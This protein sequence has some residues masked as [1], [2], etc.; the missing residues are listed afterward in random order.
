ML[1]IS[2][3]LATVRLSV[4]M[5]LLHTFAVVKVKYVLF[6]KKFFSGYFLNSMTCLCKI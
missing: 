4:M 6:S 1:L 2:L 3:S 5:M